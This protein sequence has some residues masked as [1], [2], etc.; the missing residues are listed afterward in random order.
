VL[1]RVR[2]PQGG[3]LRL[4]ARPVLPTPELPVRVELR[5]LDKGRLPEATKGGGLGVKPVFPLLAVGGVGG[6]LGAR[7]LGGGGG[8][9]ELEERTEKTD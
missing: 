3:R 9:N 2:V 5:D 6:V 8:G 1:I 4:V 7:T